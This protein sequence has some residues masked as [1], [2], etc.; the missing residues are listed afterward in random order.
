MTS[1]SS[2]TRHIR[3]APRES[4]SLLEDVRRGLSQR[5]RRLPFRLL[6][7]AVGSYS[8][9]ASYIRELREG[10]VQVASFTGTTQRVRKLQINFRNH[11]KIVVVDGTTAFVGGHNVGSS[12]AEGNRVRCPEFVEHME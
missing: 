1:T 4:M 8:L 12:V 2:R 5:P 10:G 6:Y 7:D 9:P 3:I 11:R